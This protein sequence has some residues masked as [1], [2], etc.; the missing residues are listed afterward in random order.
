MTQVEEYILE[1]SSPAKEMMQ[2][3]QSIFMSCAPQMEAR[4]IYNIPFYYYFGRLCYLNPKVG[5]VDLGFCRGA[6]LSPHPLLGRTE[7]KEVRIINFTHLTA[8]DETILTP[9]IFEAMI[10]NELNRKNRKQKPG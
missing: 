1:Q 5:S 4:L 2:K 6:L 8:I 10:L 7:L 9:L 3:L